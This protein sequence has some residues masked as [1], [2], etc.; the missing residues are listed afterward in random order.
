[1]TNAY[2]KDN[3]H[4]VIESRHSDGEA[5]AIDNIHNLDK[6]QLEKRDIVMIDIADN[7]AIESKDYKPEEDPSLYHSA[8]TGRGP[9]QEG[10]QPAAK[11]VMTCYKLVT[12]EFKWFGLQ[13]K[14]ENFIQH[15]IQGVFTKFH[16]QLFCWLDRWYGMTLDEIRQIEE[17]TKR[18]LDEVMMILSFFILVKVLMKMCR[19]EESTP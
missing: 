8:R 1:M 4:L 2:M 6:K 18:E 10:W 17:K 7:K 9:L 13:G 19:K 15:I 12:V 14:I 11:P 3:F 5:G 16:R